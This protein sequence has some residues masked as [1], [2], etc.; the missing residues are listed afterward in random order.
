MT[1]RATCS[2][3]PGQIPLRAGARSSSIEPGTV[4]ADVIDAASAVSKANGVVPYEDWATP[5]F[6]DTLTAGIQELMAVRITPQEFAAQVEKDY[7]DFQ[8]SRT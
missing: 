6:Y 2:F 7:A 3:E 1:T 4:L 8:T 5:T